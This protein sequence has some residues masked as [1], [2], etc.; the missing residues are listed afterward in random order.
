M[1][2]ITLVQQLHSKQPV[3]NSIQEVLHN[4]Q[5]W[6]IDN[7]DEAKWISEAD[8]MYIHE[9]TYT[10]G[11]FDNSPLVLNERIM[12]QNTFE[13]YKKTMSHIR[14]NV[15]W[16]IPL[17]IPQS[18]YD[19][20][21]MY[22]TLYTAHVEH[23]S[24]D[25]I[26]NKKSGSIPA[27]MYLWGLAITKKD[28]KLSEIVS[29]QILPLSIESINHI[30]KQPFEMRKTLWTQWVRN[31]PDIYMFQKIINDFDQKDAAPLLYK[32]LE[33][34]LPEYAQLAPIMAS[35]NT[36]V[37]PNDDAPISKTISSTNL[38]NDPLF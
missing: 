3:Y 8:L 15:E 16:E 7:E 36:Y 31:T 11:L 17:L 23:D 4:L 28:T 13:E 10:L 5:E 24:L 27:R 26:L 21:R 9:K 19:T 1:N 25:I 22:H 18:I 29:R 20:F 32:I 33:K 35:L 30:E 6:S 38:F 14:D 2:I 37:L 12:D 34:W